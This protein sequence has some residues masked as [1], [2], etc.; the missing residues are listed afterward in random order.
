MQKLKGR[1]AWLPGLPAVLAVPW[2]SVAR[3]PA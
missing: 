1:V 3:Q 2:Q